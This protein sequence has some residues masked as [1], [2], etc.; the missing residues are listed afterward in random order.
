[1]GALGGVGA[2][3]GVC[4]LYRCTSGVSSSSSSS[5]KL[6]TT[7]RHF[8]LLSSSSIFKRPLMPRGPVDVFLREGPS[9]VGRF[10]TTFLV[11]WR[12]TSFTSCLLLSLELK[13][14]LLCL[15]T[16]CRRYAWVSRISTSAGQSSVGTS[17]TY[18]SAR[19]WPWVLHRSDSAL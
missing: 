3:G 7:L 2:W 6:A 1:V 14:V 4:V 11:M 12:S 8:R 17:E 5:I 19:S 9:D 16:L 13:V 18:T 15:V 10:P